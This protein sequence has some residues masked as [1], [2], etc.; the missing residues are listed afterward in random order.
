MRA[1]RDLPGLIPRVLLQQPVAEVPAFSRAAGR[2]NGTAGPA[3]VRLASPSI[4]AVCRP[5]GG[6]SSIL[7]GRRHSYACKMIRHEVPLDDYMPKSRVAVEPVLQ[8]VLGRCG[9]NS[10]FPLSPSRLRSI[11][12]KRWASTLSFT[13]GA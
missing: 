12:H 5:A 2:K 10:T 6:R 8:L 3:S 13:L 7:P 9:R 4:G 1:D 11:P